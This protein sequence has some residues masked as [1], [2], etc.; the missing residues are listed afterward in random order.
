MK[1]CV[2]GSGSKGNTTYFEIENTK[3]LIDCGLSHRQ[4]RN[5]LDQKDL[6]L[7]N[8]DG[9]LIT[10]EHSDHIGGLNVTLPKTD[11]SL[12]V[13][14]ETLES[15]YHKYTSNLPFDRVVEITPYQEFT[16][17]D[18]KVYP[19]SVSHDAADAVG[20]VIFY[21]DKKIVYVTDIG[22]LP[23][24]DYEIL[25]NADMYVFESNYDVHLLFTSNRPFY[26]K[27]RID[28]VK[29]HMSNADTAYNLAQLIGDK[30]KHIVLA[31]PSRECNTAELALETI[32]E[33]FDEYGIDQSQLTIE[34]ATQDVPTKVYEM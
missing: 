19:L 23:Q 31:H 25:G 24:K 4:I 3:F 33:V 26:L 8:L 9:I 11:A 10:H 6:S 20:Y 7:E 18:V 1:V 14:E 28:S 21:Q 30:T 17:K 22:Y 16:L 5:R 32:T 34:V 13:T 2:L 27:Q 12:Y 29:G 15:F